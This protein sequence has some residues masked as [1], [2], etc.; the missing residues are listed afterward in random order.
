M[1]E[2]QAQFGDAQHWMKRALR[3]TVADPA[4]PVR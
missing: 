2:R 3:A 1:V 4:L